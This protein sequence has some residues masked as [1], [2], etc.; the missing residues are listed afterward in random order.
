MRLYFG[1]DKFCSLH[2]YARLAQHFFSNGIIFKTKAFGRKDSGSKIHRIRIT[3]ETKNN[4][5][6]LGWAP[7]IYNFKQVSQMLLRQPA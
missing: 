4:L 3:L 6:G 7:R 1:L 5:E 2:K